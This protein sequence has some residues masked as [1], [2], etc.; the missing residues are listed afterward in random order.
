[1]PALRFVLLVTLF[2]ALAC[3]DGSIEGG[4]ELSVEA[5]DVEKAH[6]YLS[7]RKPSL[8]SALLP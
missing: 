5:E 8:D 4:Q 7:S 2:L 3:G 6:A 1:M